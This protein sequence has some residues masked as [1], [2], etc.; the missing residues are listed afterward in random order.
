MVLIATELR[1]RAAMLISGTRAA[2][3]RKYRIIL[4]AENP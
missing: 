1:R 3:A 2:R 4:G